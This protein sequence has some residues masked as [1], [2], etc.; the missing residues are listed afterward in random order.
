VRELG[1]RAPLTLTAL[2]R[3]GELYNMQARYQKAEPLL[4]RAF[5]LRH[6]VLGPEHPDTIESMVSLGFVKGWS[7]SATDNQE[8]AKLRIQ[9]FEIGRKVLPENHPIHLKALSSLADLYGVMG[10]EMLPLYQQGLKHA[11]EVLGPEHELTL[12]FERIVGTTHAW[13]F[14]LEQAQPLLTEALATSQR[15]CGPDHPETLD[16]MRALSEFYIVNLQLS[17]AH[18]LLSDTLGRRS[19]REPPLHTQ[20]LQLS[21]FLACVSAMEGQFP[22]ATQTLDTILDQAGQLQGPKDRLIRFCILIRAVLFAMQGQSEELETWCEDMMERFEGDDLTVAEIHASIGAWQT[23]YSNTKIHDT[24]L[25]LKHAM[26]SCELSGWSNSDY[27]C[28]LATVYA[29]VGDFD[30]AIEWQQRA[31][32]MVEREQSMGYAAYYRWVLGFLKSGR[33]YRDS[34]I[35]M[36]AFHA[37]CPGDQ[38]RFIPHVQKRYDYCRQ[39]FGE[40]HG[41]TQGC[42]YWLAHLYDTLNKPE[43]AAAWR[44][45]LVEL[46]PPH[47]SPSPVNEFKQ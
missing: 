43:E 11:Q 44:A 31:I 39:V 3:L 29:A 10:Y 24:G 32:D 1:E 20:T 45:K 18:E 22:L 7:S 25:A 14:E 36:L 47:S 40:N 16:C 19:R 17:E 2:N 21:F 12:A 34:L 15:V 26:K 28:N 46:M 13:A 38:E 27:I 4:V 41:E 5:Q 8:G 33:P 42:I 6:E 37:C 23:I 9:A 30:K 35:T